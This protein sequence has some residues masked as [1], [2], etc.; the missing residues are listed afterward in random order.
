[1]KF[2]KL[3]LAATLM[4]GVGAAPTQ[5][6]IID[7]PRF[8]VLGLVIVWGADDATGGAPVVSD[9]VIGAA[10]G[11]DLIAADGQAVVTGTL[12]PVGLTENGDITV[13]GQTS[14]FTDGNSNG[15]VDAGEY[16]ALSAFTLD[17]TSDVS[18]DGFET[19]THFYVA[20]NTGFTIAADV[21]AGPSMST[22]YDLTDATFSMGVT[23]S[24]EVTPGGLNFG[25]AAINANFVDDATFP[26]NDNTLADIDGTDVYVGTER[27]AGSPGT[28]LEQS[29]RF[30]NTYTLGGTAGYDLSQGTGT[31]DAIV[32]YTIGTP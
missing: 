29:V 11:I 15:V 19:T 23:T 26:E 25:G 16:S 10:G 31:F 4:A 1:M 8:Q 28:I 7:N 18:V 32:T 22:D 9:F 17:G 12:N 21:S 6:S 13:A 30:D 2:R 5:A 24:G 27:T 14:T 20:S 3:L